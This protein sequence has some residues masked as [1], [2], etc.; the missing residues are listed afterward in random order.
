MAQTRQC[1]CHFGCVNICASFNRVWACTQ[2][3]VFDIDGIDIDTGK[4]PMECQVY[5]WTYG[6]LRDHGHRN[7]AV[8]LGQSGGEIQLQQTDRQHYDTGGGGSVLHQW[9]AIEE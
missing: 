5:F 3:N 7:P 2:D 4:G 9:A 6:I 8:L 1:V